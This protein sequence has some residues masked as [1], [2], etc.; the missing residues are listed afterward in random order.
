MSHGGRMDFF[1]GAN[2]PGGFYSLFNELYNPEEN[3]RLYIIKGGPGTG[4]SGLMK[5]IAGQ[6]EKEGYL[7][8]RI[9]CSSDPESL[10]AVI[11]P[12]LR[13]AV[14]DGTAPHVLE[15]KYPGV[16]EQII[17]LGEFWNKASLSGNAAEIKRYTAAN[18]EEHQRCIR[19]LSAVNA[20]DNDSLKTVAHCIDRVKIDNYAKRL[21]G[22]EFHPKTEQKGRPGNVKKRFLSAITPEG[23]KVLF[24]SVYDNCDRVV[25]IK[26]SYG[27]CASIL[28]ESLKQAALS[29]GYDV[30]ACYCPLR[31]DEK[32]EH[33]IIPELSFVFFTEN[34]YHSL[35]VKASKTIHTKRFCDTERLYESMFRLRFNA[36][37]KAELIEESISRLSLAKALHDRLESYYI[38]AMDFKKVE[39]QSELIVNEILQGIRS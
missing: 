31:P 12:F 8:E 11:F 30:I 28:L 6:I 3:W 20:I 10:D 29:R 23:V 39:A 27:L 14:A 17:N 26:D 19:Y 21:A 4:K 24:D 35:P 25:A 18:S 38:S 9:P 2:S 15:P 37:A 16:A 36:K 13:A 1:L 34:A 5:R 33:L 7:C 22:R 32:L